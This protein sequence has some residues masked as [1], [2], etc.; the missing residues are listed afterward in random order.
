MPLTALR[1]GYAADSLER[2]VNPRAIQAAMGHESPETT[3]GY[4]HSESLS[5]PSPLDVMPTG[6]LAPWDGLAWQVPPQPLQVNRPAA[7]R[8]RSGKPETTC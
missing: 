6:T 5:V 1:H 8:S 7:N 4:L 2:G 3:M